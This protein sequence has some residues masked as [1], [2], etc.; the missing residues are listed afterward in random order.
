MWGDSTVGGSAMWRYVLLLGIVSASPAIGW[1]DTVQF[2]VGPAKTDIVYTGPTSIVLHSSG[3]DGTVLAGQSL[4]LN[5]ELGDDV[6]A[7][8]GGLSS[9]G[10]FGVLLIVPTNAG[11]FPGFA[12]PTT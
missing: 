7:R 6:L 12:G 3:L 10:L 1:C 4:S 9:N 8:L 2:T 11:I 5:L